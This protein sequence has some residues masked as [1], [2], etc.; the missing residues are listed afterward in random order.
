MEV[1]QIILVGP[2]VCDYV[3][4]VC[5]ETWSKSTCAS[6]WPHN[7]FSLTVIRKEA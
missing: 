5:E 3:L 7:H 1:N 6:W 2:D 4:F